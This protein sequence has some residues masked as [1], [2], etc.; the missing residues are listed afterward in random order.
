MDFSKFEED[1]FRLDLR[2]DF[3]GDVTIFAPDLSANIAR[4]FDVERGSTFVALD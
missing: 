1:R 4:M 3:F 2:G